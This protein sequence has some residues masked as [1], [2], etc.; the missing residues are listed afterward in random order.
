MQ[1]EAGAIQMAATCPSCILL[2]L[3]PLPIDVDSEYHPCGRVYVSDVELQKLRDYA[4]RGVLAAPIAQ[5]AVSK[6]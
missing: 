3:T 1:L 6:N 5:D 2:A 4:C